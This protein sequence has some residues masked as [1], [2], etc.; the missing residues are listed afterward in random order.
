MVT[1]HFLFLK[2]LTTDLLLLSSV[3]IIAIATKFDDLIV[4]LFTRKKGWEKSRQEAS[5]LWDDKLDTPLRN[6]KFP[7]REYIRL[8][9]TFFK[10]F[11]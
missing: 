4:Q 5:K 1:L 7:P 8:E 2:P 6:F 3:P 9:G 10:W 11:M